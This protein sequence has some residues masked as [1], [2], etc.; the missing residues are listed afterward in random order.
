MISPLEEIVKGYFSYSENLHPDYEKLLRQF[1]LSSGAVSV[2]DQD[3]KIE[4]KIGHVVKGK[5][6]AMELTHYASD[7][8]LNRNSNTFCLPPFYYIP[9]CNYMFYGFFLSV[10]AFLMKAGTNTKLTLYLPA[11]DNISVNFVYRPEIAQA[12]LMRRLES[13]QAIENGSFKQNQK[14]LFL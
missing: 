12:F 13:I 9:S 5:K 2:V 4:A 8:E 3:Y 10:A 11:M 6:N 1:Y 7:L 14:E